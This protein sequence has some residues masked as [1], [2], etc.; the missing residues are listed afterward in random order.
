MT[1]WHT[2]ISISKDENVHDI[3]VQMVRQLRGGSGGGGG[4]G[5]GYSGGRGGYYGGGSSYYGSS[6]SSSGD[7]ISMGV[8][9]AIIIVFLGVAG[10]IFYLQCKANGNN[11]GSDKEFDAAVDSQRMKSTSLSSSQTSITATAYKPTS[12]MLCGIGMK[13][14]NRSIII[15]SINPN[16]LFANSGLKVGMFVR[17]INHLST[18]GRSAAEMTQLIKEAIGQVTIVTG[19]PYP[20]FE[21]YSGTFDMSYVDRGKTFR[22]HVMLELQHDNNIRGYRVTGT[23]A[24]ADGTATIIDGLAAYDGD[25]W[26]LDEVSSGNDAGLK[27]LSTGKLDWSKNTFEGVWRA[28]TGQSGQY[29]SFQ[30][31]NVSKT[32][33]PRTPT[34]EETAPPVVVATAVSPFSDTTGQINDHTPIVTAVADSSSPI[35][36][37]IANK[38]TKDVLVGIGIKAPNG[39]SPQITTINPDGLFSTSALRVGMYIHSINN[40]SMSDKTAAESTQ[41]IKQLVGEVTIAAGWNIPAPVTAAPL[42]SAPPAEPEVYVPP[43]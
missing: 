32:F 43:V 35:V 21:S 7:G 4:G 40:V 16:G 31:T 6:R 13:G 25:A 42:P 23:T 1:E 15:S 39:H 34:A 8:V 41:V 30:Y 11:I 2:D 12:Q 19:G 38:P 36:I 10:F 26:W 22:G 27:V 5:G 24:D 14:Q 29:S 18:K 33:T 9:M 28:N 3:V 37:A 17:T 20:P